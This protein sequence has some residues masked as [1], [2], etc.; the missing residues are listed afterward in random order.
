MQ[1]FLAIVGLL[2][3]MACKTGSKVL[4][5]DTMKLVIWDLLQVDEFA[6]VYLAKDSSRNILD[7][8]R[9][10]YAK[11]FAIHK[12]DQQQF[13]ESLTWYRANVD[14]FKVL[15]DSVGVYSARQREERFAAPLSSPAGLPSR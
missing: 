9:L 7:S 13:F 8:S 6:T 2:L 14:Q 12:V 11:V 10:L 4:P 3:L 1:R 5:V 15:I